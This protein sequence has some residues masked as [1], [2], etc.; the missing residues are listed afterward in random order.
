LTIE[1][2]KGDVAIEV[3]DNGPGENSPRAAL[4]RLIRSFTAEK[5]KFFLYDQEAADD[6]CG[7]GWGT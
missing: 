3:C 7:I 6:G 5:F 2:K 4:E 1:H